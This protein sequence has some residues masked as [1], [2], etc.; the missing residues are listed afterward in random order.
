MSAA[1][2][3]RLALIGTGEAAGTLHLPAAL[4]SEL[5]EVA[6]LVDPTIERAEALARRYGG[7]PEICAS[8]GDVR[9]P[10]DGAIIATPNDTHRD[11]AVA[12]AA[13]GIHCLIEKPLATRVEDAEEICR[14]AEKHGIVV[15]VGYY[16]RFSD[17]VILLKRLLDTEYFG[18]IRRFHFQ[19]GTLGGWSPL[20][21]YNLDRR[22]SGG[23]VLV[24]S[25]THFLDLMLYW[26]GYP[27]DC[28]MI[29]DATDGPEAQCLV[30]VRYR[31]GGRRFDG[32]IRLSKVYDLN[33]G[34]V[35]DGE[36]GRAILRFDAS[37]L[38]F[39]PR[40]N[41]QLQMVLQPR[42]VPHFPSGV[43]KFQLQLENFVSACR[44]ERPPL[45]DG[46]QGLLSVRLLDQLYSRRKYLEDPGRYPAEPAPSRKPS[47]GG[48]ATE[49]MKV[50]IFGASGFV[51]S[52]LV[53]RLEQEGV[54]V[55]AAIHSAGNAWRLARHGIPLR[56]VDL[57]SRAAVREAMRGCTH[58][59]NCTRGSDE[60]MIGGL[61]NL[62]AEAKAQGVRRLIHLSSVAVYGDPPP[63]DSVHEES[64]ARPEPG[65]YGAVK[66]RQ[67]KLV[68][69]ACA[70]GLSCAILCPPNITGMY[71]PFVCS[72]L[73]DMHCGSLALV[74]DGTMP[75]NLVDVENLCHAIELALKT[76]SADGQRMFV[77]DG[78]GLT[79]RDFTDELLPLTEFSTPLASLPRSLIAVPTTMP[80]RG[81][82]LGTM[83]H[84][85][86]DDVRSALRKDPLFGKMETAAGNLVRKLPSRFEDALRRRIGGPS[87]VAK[88]T[89]RQSFDSRYNLQ[90]LRGV[91]HS[92]DRAARVIGYTRVIE[93]RESMATFRRWYTTTRGMENESW[94]LVRELLR[95]C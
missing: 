46:R 37:S 83:R 71:S 20:S 47:L 53:E 54:D 87:R 76:D 33:S 12:C 23:G 51:G 11:L 77:T 40:E 26:F 32:T 19:Y 9:S 85:V 8:I 43:E 81:S 1:S 38:L 61:S 65:S 80:R 44:R 2:R 92:C 89:T 29:D 41:P 31:S 34:L 94:P 58:V 90:Q 52:T 82:L 67:D 84:L 60:V 30:T 35:I 15:A 27:D 13:R 86:S 16:M 36:K 39:R 91:T 64:D 56:A 57:M 95:S 62:L 69:G 21:G 75:I 68:A 50:A 73:E 7:R 10:V 63:A 49:S 72:V 88:V 6:T 70:G 17:E 93:F 42:D 5:V 48:N 24:V 14:A 28:E 45:V 79:W 4:A 78:D 74:E 55:M 59:V 22:A 3:F 66:L 18:H 25:G